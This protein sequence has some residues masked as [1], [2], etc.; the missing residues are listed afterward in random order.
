MSRCVRTAKGFASCFFF[1]A[2]KTI[3]NGNFKTR[4]FA[5]TRQKYI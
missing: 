5:E 1:R 3:K 4:K 2:K